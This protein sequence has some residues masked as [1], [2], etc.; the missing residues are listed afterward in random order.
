MGAGDL[1]ISVNWCFHC[2]V[3][4]L[5]CSGPAG[6]LCCPGTQKHKDLY[7]GRLM[8]SCHEGENPLEV[9]ARGRRPQRAVVRVSSAASVLGASG[10]YYS[11]CGYSELFSSVQSLSRVRLFATP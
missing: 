3:L 8:G 7:S 6:D 4:S 9:S 1:D 5:P 2:T 10:L 11:H